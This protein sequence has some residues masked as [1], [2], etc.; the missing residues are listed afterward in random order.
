LPKYLIVAARHDLGVTDLK[1][2]KAKK[3]SAGIGVPLD[4]AVIA[5]LDVKALIAGTLANLLNAALA[6]IL[7]AV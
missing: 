6:G 1:D 2:L 7:L 5:R 4:V 3:R